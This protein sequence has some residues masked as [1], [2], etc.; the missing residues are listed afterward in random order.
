MEFN[1][2]NLVSRTALIDLQRELPGYKIFRILFSGD[3]LDISEDA[4][5]WQN[6]YMYQ[7]IIAIREFF[8]SNLTSSPLPRPWSAPLGLRIRAR[9]FSAYV[10][11]IR[12]PDDHCSPPF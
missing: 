12:R 9:W 10:F 4:P 6:L 8:S 2:M 5:V 3:F 1:E 7:N 11:S